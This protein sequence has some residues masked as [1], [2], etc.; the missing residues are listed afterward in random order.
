[1]KFTIIAF[2]SLWIASVTT[3]FSQSEREKSDGK[4]IAA[5][6]QGDV[7]AGLGEVNEETPQL[8]PKDVISVKHTVTAGEA[9]TA[10]LVFSNGA[11][12]SL[13]QKTSL[14]I[15]EFLQDPFST[16]YAMPTE[17]TEPN[18]STTK[19]NLVEGEVVC[20]V[21]KLNTDEGTSF[22]INT[23]A[24]AAGI[25]GTTFAVTYV[26]DSDGSGK[27]RYVLSVTEGEVSLTDANGNVTRVLAGRELAIQFRST[28]NEATGEATIQEIISREIR[29]IPQD[30]LDS[31]NRAAEQGEVIADTVVF[32]VNQENLLGILPIAEG[33]PA[34]APAPPSVTEVDPP[35]NFETAE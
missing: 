6:V 31:I 9:S 3:S 32:N 17:D 15:A 7:R 30:R 12:I 19:L 11:T 33:A 34:V 4:V 28:V 22:E 2:L 23:P 10:T 24:G 1:M 5:A 27:G 25:R 35:S 14:V 16:P 20:K 26:P 29:D 21:K 8:K 13:K 18:V